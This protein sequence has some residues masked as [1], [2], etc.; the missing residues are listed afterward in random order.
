MVWPFKKKPSPPSNRKRKFSGLS[1]N[2][3]G[4]PKDQGE[5]EEEY[6][7]ESANIEEDSFE[8]IPMNMPD[9]MDFDD[10]FDSGEEIPM[11]IPLD[12]DDDDDDFDLDDEV[13]EI[14]LDDELDRDSTD[15]EEVIPSS[16]GMGTM[17]MS[18]TGGGQ[19]PAG[20][21]RPTAP[22]AMAGGSGPQRAPLTEDQIK[23]GRALL[24]GGTLTKEEIQQ[25]L[26]S[27]GKK[28]GVL[29]KVL[30]NTG[31]VE[32][33]KV[34]HTLL[35][36]Y[37]IPRLNIQ[38]T[39]IPNSTLDLINTDFAKKHRMI[40]IEKIGNIICVAMDNIH[41][42]QALLEL[43]EATGYKVCVLQCSPEGMEF[44]L[45]RYYAQPRGPQT[46]GRV[47]APAAPSA[48]QP[49]PAAP[50]APA[51]GGQQQAQE[52]AAVATAISI[53][54]VPLQQQ[55]PGANFTGRNVDVMAQWFHIHLSGKPVVPEEA[56]L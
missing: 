30:L 38:N 19:P 3:F 41:N 48:G 53:T 44:T 20:M 29:G 5:E 39:K 47:P 22:G 16:G 42:S 15:D 36:R 49:A 40:P 25:E 11:S 7:D 50:T 51:A 1:G 10:E 35:A 9:D 34:I 33:Q 6:V 32:E 13:D 43:R 46:M 27:S 14:N 31:Y 55:V 8:E 56:V 18:K 28:D 23:L 37:R 17:R 21:K 52:P 45:K 26:V 4:K 12:D 24:A 54:A 2:K